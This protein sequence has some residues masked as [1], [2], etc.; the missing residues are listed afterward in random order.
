MRS[1]LICL[2]IA[3]ALLAGCTT[4]ADM[5]ALDVNSPSQEMTGSI[6]RL[7]KPVPQEEVGTV[8]T[9]PAPV[10][11]PQRAMAAP[12]PAIIDPAPQVEEQQPVPAIMN[13]PEPQA[14]P[15]PLVKQ[16]MPGATGKAFRGHKTYSPRFKD[17]DPISF[18]RVKP[19][20]FA[21]H[22]VDVSRWQGNV[23]WET[24]RSR[25]ANFAFIKATDGGDHLDPMFRKHW[26]GAGK[27]GLKRGAYH[28]F[29]WCRS[30]GEQADWFIRNV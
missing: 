17:A 20:S 8:R 30:G 6:L 5:S 21:V 14:E 27:A 19:K 1:S 16:S 18:G 23:D 25:G 2:S 24:L 15:L 29:Y 26:N 10:M 11:A 9:L 28:F 13:V 7:A 12:Q 3:S 4:A 22:G